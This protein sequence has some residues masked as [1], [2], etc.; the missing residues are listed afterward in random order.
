MADVFRKGYAAISLALTMLLYALVVPV[1]L[2]S[3]LILFTAAALSNFLKER[4]A[5]FRKEL[6]E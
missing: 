2:I 1:L 4:V 6:G 5:S 3:S